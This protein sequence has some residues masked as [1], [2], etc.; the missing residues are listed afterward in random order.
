MNKK[1]KIS[2]YIVFSTIASIGLYQTLSK[3]HSREM[4]KSE[5]CLRENIEALSDTDNNTETVKCG[6]KEEFIDGYPCPVH[7]SIMIGFRGTEYSYSPI[8]SGTRFKSGLKGY[9]YSCIQMGCSPLPVDNVQE[10]S[11]SSK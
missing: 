4:S 2:L 1:Q 7:P 5:I 3:F 9:N 11:C 10:Y 8:G 6:T